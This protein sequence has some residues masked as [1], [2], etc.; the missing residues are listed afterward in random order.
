MHSCKALAIREVLSRLK[1]I[2]RR[3]VVIKSDCLLVVQTI[4]SNVDRLSSLSL[5]ISNYKCLLAT[6]DNVKVE[7]VRKSTNVVTHLLAREARS[8]PSLFV[9][10]FTL[11]NYIASIIVGEMQ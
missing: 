9:W 5:V 11:P 2:N 4:H 1:D 10:G 8:Y 3:E 6:L 7:F